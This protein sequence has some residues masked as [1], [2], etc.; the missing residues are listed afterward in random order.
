M[1]R[2]PEIQIQ[3]QPQLHHKSANTKQRALR[4]NQQTAINWRRSLLR[5][6]PCLFLERVTTSCSHAADIPCLFCPCDG[7]KRNSLKERF[8][9]YCVGWCAQRQ[10]CCFSFSVWL[11]EVWFTSLSCYSELTTCRCRERYMLRYNAFCQF[12]SQVELPPGEHHNTQPMDLPH[13]LN[14]TIPLS[15]KHANIFFWQKATQL[16]ILLHLLKHTI[17]IIPRFHY[18]FSYTLGR[19]AKAELHPRTSH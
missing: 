18:C 5:S 12:S 1:S 3:I 10:R 11:A 16:F 6:G 9:R 8:S 19:G 13:F 7:K 14:M 17:K 15:Y 4:E 2:W